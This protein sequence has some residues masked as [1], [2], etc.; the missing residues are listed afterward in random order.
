[1]GKSRSSK[2]GKGGGLSQNRVESTMTRALVFEVTNA[3][4]HTTAG[5]VA[6]P[7]PSVGVHNL[8]SE[9]ICTPL[10]PQNFA[11]Y[12][13]TH[14]DKVVVQRL[15]H[16]IQYGFD[17]GYRGPVAGHTSPNLVSAHAH[18]DVIDAHLR[19]ECKAGRIAGPFPA[20]PL[21]DLRCSGLGV[22]PKKGGD[23]RVIYHLSA[24][25]GHSINDHIDPNK[26]SLRYSSVDDAV[27]I[28]QKLGRGTLLAKINL[29]NAFRQCPVRTEDWHTLVFIRENSSTLTSAYPSACVQHHI[30]LT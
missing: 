17:I 5:I 15:L 10:R 3:P 1:M 28:C 4:T 9:P 14:P 21:P 20:P 25:F 24:P 11:R 22:V 26:F 27:S 2:T 13:S 16:G 12:L 18:P 30:Y 19:K 8:V 6:D 23:W 7:T 29:K